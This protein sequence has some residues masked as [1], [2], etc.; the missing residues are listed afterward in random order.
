MNLI[1]IGAIGLACLTL[2]SP[3]V[4]DQA[5]LLAPD[6]LAYSSGW[7]VPTSP[8]AGLKAFK[9]AEARDWLQ[10]NKN[11][12]PSGSTMGGMSGM[13]GMKGMGGGNMKGGAG[14]VGAAKPMQG[15]PGMGS[16]PAGGGT[17]SSGGMSGMPG[18]GGGK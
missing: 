14:S 10:M 8:T 16:E 12:T 3:C 11:V 7:R 5:F 6:N 15:M 9:P 18:M 1:F 17:G 4:A 13:A 2:T